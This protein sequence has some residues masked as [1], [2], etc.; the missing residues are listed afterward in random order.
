MQHFW[1]A[2]AATR[3]AEPVELFDS[4]TVAITK[5]LEIESNLLKV[6]LLKIFLILLE[7]ESALLPLLS[8]FL[9]AKEALLS[10]CAPRG[11]GGQRT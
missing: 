10:L 9:E 5:S 8:A 3:G 1:A 6:Y 4:C 7:S 11:T 2:T